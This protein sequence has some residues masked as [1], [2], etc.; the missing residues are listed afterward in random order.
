MIISGFHNLTAPASAKNDENYLI[1]QCKS[2]KDLNVADAYG[3]EIM[4]LYDHYRFRWYTQHATGTTRKVAL[5]EPPVLT[6]DATW[7]ERYFGSDP[8]NTADRYRFCPPLRYDSRTK[9]WLSRR[10]A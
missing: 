7:A 9:R 3:I 5:K 6:V 2:S 1:I 8:M 10:E 4:R